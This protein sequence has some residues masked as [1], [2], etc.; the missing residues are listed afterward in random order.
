MDSLLSNDLLY[1]I[2]G[3]LDVADATRFSSVRGAV[4]L[5]VQRVMTHSQ[6]AAINGVLPLT[7]RASTVL[8]LVL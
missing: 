3:E 6:Q 2:F 5:A 1:R 7:P 8:L 4:I